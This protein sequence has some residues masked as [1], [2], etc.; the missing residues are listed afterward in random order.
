MILSPFHWALVPSGPQCEVRM[1][2]STLVG[3]VTHPGCRGKDGGQGLESVCAC[4]MVCSACS[5][6]SARQEVPG[7]FQEAGSVNSV[8]RGLF[9]NMHPRVTPVF[10]T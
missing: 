6:S 3:P 10:S 2:I 9:C 8:P 1:C 4:P 5:D 7:T